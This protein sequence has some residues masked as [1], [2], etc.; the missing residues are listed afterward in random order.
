MLLWTTMKGT[1]SQDAFGLEI[2]IQGWWS[3]IADL[4]ANSQPESPRS[5]G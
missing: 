5:C 2:E 3:S 1:V 4:L